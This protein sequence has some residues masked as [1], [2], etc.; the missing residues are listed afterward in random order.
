MFLVGNTR[1][2][3][4]GTDI[5]DIDEDQADFIRNGEEVQVDFG[6]GAPVLDEQGRLAGSLETLTSKKTL[7][8]P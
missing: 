7:S 5:V 8:T 6:S 3:G 2:T 1:K 4:G